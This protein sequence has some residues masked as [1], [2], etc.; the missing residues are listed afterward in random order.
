MT[1]FCETIFF[2]LKI[3][4]FSVTWWCYCFVTGL[5]KTYIANIL[6]CEM[7]T[8]LL[9][10]LWVYYVTTYC[11]VSWWHHY[12][13]FCELMMSILT[14]LW[15]G[16]VNT[17]HFVSLLTVCELMTSPLTIFQVDDVTTYH[18]VSWW[19]HYLPLSEL[20]TSLLTILKVDDVTTYRFV[21]WWLYS[22]R[23]MTSDLSEPEVIDKPHSSPG[24]SLSP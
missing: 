23:H 15:V 5:I 7:M 19:H 8:L 3:P 16:D 24:N 11:S 13:P 21:S 12:L 9:T 17:Y 18:L 20:M 22:W 10:I 4:S 6:V 2:S 14:I 1:G